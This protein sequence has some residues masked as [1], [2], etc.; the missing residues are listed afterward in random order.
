M[1]ITRKLTLNLGIRYDYLGPSVD[2][3]NRNGNFDP[4]R[5]DANTIANAGPGLANGFILSSNFKS[6]TL[7]GTPGV[8]PS[9]LTNLNKTNFSPRIGMAWDPFGDGKTAIRAGY[10]I[11]YV[12][13]SNQTQLQL[14]T[15][16]SFFQ[17]GNS[18]N[19]GTTLANPF[20]NLPV[21]SQFPILPKFPQFTG[22]N[23]A[24][25]PQ[26]SAPLLTINPI[27]TNLHTPYA[28]HYNFSIQR[29]LPARFDL[30]VGY[31][32]SQGVH[33]LNGLQLNQA[34]LANAN[35][36][37]RGITAN[38]TVNASARVSVAGFS[39]NG[40]NEVTDIGH[41][42]YNALAVTLNRRVAN[43]FI[44]AAYTFAKSID[45]N[46]GGSTQDL[47]TQIGNQLVPS[48]GRALSDFDRTH[49]V[50]LT[51]QYDV[52]AY[53]HGFVRQALGKWSIG[54]L[55]TFQ[56]AVP[57]AFTCS[58]CSSSNVYGIT[59]GLSPS[60]VGNFSTLSKGA[61]SRNY[62]DPGTSM[63]N[64]GILAVPPV[65]TGGGVLASNL[66]A[67]GG[68]GN[69]TYIVGTNGTA[70]GVGQL[71]GTLPRNPGIRGPFQQ[72]H[73]FYIAKIIPIRERLNL[74]FDGQF[75]NVFNHSVFAAP[76]GAVGSSAL[77]RV[78]STVTQPRIVQLAA[79]L[80]F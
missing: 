21:P 39:P 71:Y 19:P 69:Q 51:Y 78:S 6:S 27:Q 58:T 80:I 66:N 57:I 53:G 56:S 18:T 70:S 65:V 59:S 20:P 35:S 32:G 37:I 22:Y 14:L 62:L 72:Q 63:F 30:E 28:E 60:I 26:F 75:F 29:Q 15:A 11:Y 5:L 44:Q 2:R 76:S 25:T 7:N 48:L 47:G 74:R 31:L 45:N 36:P 3:L 55:T 64:S 24:G 49:R 33:L 68:P 46:S 52:P 50:Q 23:A 67:Q 13:I 4:S 16:A 79:R 61:D 77:G 10:G 54:G 9:T 73:D 17:L 1:K 40:L 38:A 42:S 43:M 12:R 8:D 41:S 34:L